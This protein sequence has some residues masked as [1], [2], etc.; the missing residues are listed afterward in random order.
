MKMNHIVRAWKD[1]DY[2]ASLSEAE[3][4]LVPRNPAGQF[5]LSESDLRRVTGGAFA[6]TCICGTT[7]V[8]S[9]VKPPAACP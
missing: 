9:C 3:R 4:S 1:A 6:D 2:R 7:V 8:D 5:E